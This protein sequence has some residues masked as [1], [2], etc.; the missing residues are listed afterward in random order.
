M[1]KKK[2]KAL[3]WSYD[4]A[5]RTATLVE[6]SLQNGDNKFNIYLKFTNWEYNKYETAVQF[7]LLPVYKDEKYEGDKS[8]GDSDWIGQYVIHLE[9]RR[10]FYF[11]IVG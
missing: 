11:M 7:E 9:D 10:S 6:N 2:N 3:G 8:V 5:T 1:M 4:D